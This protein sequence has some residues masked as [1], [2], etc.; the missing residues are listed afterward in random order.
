MITL[1][2]YTKNQINVLL[3][4]RATNNFKIIINGIIE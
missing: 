4:S 1:D 3:Q 2:F